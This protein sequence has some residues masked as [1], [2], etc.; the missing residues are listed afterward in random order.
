[1]NILSVFQ[2]LHNIKLL[3]IKDVFISIHILFL[4]EDLVNS[5]FNDFNLCGNDRML[6]HKLQMSPK[7]ALCNLVR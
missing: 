7:E 2:S 4:E 3:K 1:M 6:L 5:V